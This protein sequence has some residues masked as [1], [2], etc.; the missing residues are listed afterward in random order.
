[1]DKT[2]K[3]KGGQPTRYKAEYCELAFNYCLLGAS[4]AELAQFFSVAESTIN[5]WKKDHPEFLESIKRGKVEADASV[6]SRLY[7]RAMGYEHDDVH[8]SNFQGQ[9][10]LTPI[11]KH[12]PPDTTAAIFWLKNRQKGKWRDK[13]EQD[14]NVTGSFADMTTE[15]LA[16]IARGGK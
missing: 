8:V 14:V 2:G 9:I 6:A 15:E 4:D 16:N 11:I 7:S 5:N 13:T 1:M 10:T 3:S 12:Y